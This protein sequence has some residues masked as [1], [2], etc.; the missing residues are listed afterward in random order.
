M[1]LML[2]LCYVLITYGGLKYTNPT[3]FERELPSRIIQKGFI[4]KAY[5][6]EALYLDTQITFFYTFGIRRFAF[7]ELLTNSSSVNIEETFIQV[8]NVDKLNTS[9]CN[10]YNVTKMFKLESLKGKT[11]EVEYDRVSIHIFTRLLIAFN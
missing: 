10:E 8:C 1:M 7:S 4:V 3:N 5:V 11:I 2:Q 6:E 9:V